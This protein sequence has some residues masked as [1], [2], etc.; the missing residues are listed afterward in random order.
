MVQGEINSNPLS[1]HTVLE[2]V[3][4]NHSVTSVHFLMM[5]VKNRDVL[6]E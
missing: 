1:Q 2:V 6:C 4:I 5:S 3:Y